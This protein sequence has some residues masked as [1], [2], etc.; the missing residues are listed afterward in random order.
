MYVK[1]ITIE[2]DCEVLIFYDKSEFMNKYFECDI[3]NSSFAS[4]SILTSHIMIHLFGDYEQ[5]H[6]C[7]I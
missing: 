5:P 3:C 2:D 1:K 7:I 6:K 4:K